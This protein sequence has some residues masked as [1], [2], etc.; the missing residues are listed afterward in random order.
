LGRMKVGYK[1]MMRADSAFY[2]HA[3]IQAALRAG[4]QISVTARM[5]KRVSAAITQIPEDA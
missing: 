5:D 2:A 4:A 3:P 1:V